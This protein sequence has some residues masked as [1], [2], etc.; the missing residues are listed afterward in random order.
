LYGYGKKKMEA[1]SVPSRERGRVKIQK[2]L[3]LGKLTRFVEE[4]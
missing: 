3:S 2:K 1:L 4:K